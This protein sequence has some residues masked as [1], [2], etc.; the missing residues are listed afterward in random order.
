MNFKFTDN[1]IYIVPNSLK[2]KLL[3]IL[4]ND[5]KIY[6]ITFISLEE[7][8]KHYFFDIK[9]DSLLYLLDKT[10]EN[11]D[12]L[13]LMLKNLYKIDITK[14]YKESKLN[15]LKRLYYD[16]KDNNYLVFDNGYKEYLLTKNI[17]ILGYSMLEPYEKEML[18]SI[19]TNYLDISGN[20]SIDTVYTYHS[21]KDE[22]ISTALKIRELN[23]KCVSYN[24]IFLAGID[25]S[26]NYL[27]KTFFSMFD[28]PLYLKSTNKL[29]SLISVKEYLKDKDI[30][31]IKDINLKS[32][33]IKIES[34]LSYAKNS[35]YYD[36]LLKD[37]LDNTTIDSIELVE[38]VK[39]LNEALD[40]PYLVSDDEYLFVLGFNQNYLPKIYKDEE[41]LS[42]NLKNK[43][44]LNTSFIKN[45]LSK[46]NLVKVLGTIK[47]LTISYKLT[48]LTGEYAKSSLLNELNLKEVDSFNY[49]YNYSRDFNSYRVSSVLDNYY[50]YHEKDNDFDFL[51]TNIDTSKYTSFD[52]K[53]KGINRE[54]TPY[55]LSYSSID[56]LAKC[57]FK[58]YLKYILKLDSFDE[59]F[60]TKIGN[61]FHSILKDSYSNNFSFEESLNKAL[62]DNPLDKRES[63]LFKRLE[64]ELQEI[65]NYNKQVEKRSF[66]TEFYGEKR[67]EIP[68][69]EHA[70]LKG[71]IDKILFKTFHDKTYYAVFDYKTGNATL[72]LDY[73]EDGLYLQLPLYI[74][75]INKSNLFDNPSFVGFF[76]QYLLQNYKDSEE[77]IKNLKLVGYTTD[78]KVILSYLDEDYENNSFVK[79]LSVKKDGE[80]SSRSKVLSDS[81][82]EDIMNSINK[83]LE[84]SLKI[85]DNNAFDIAPKIINNKN[86]SCEFC[87]FKEVCFVSAS[88]YIYLTKKEGDDNA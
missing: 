34:D 57:P 66:L 4:S 65:V 28:I 12:V 17:Y 58:Y 5:S 1:S 44:N 37:K 47:N 53:F 39:V 16:L 38:S 6:N 55:S 22:I 85:I 88:D 68:L 69:S 48:S 26:Y 86:I 27:L 23:S 67:L 45:K 73:L 49:N 43:C 13:R 84:K 21:M 41:Y 2:L 18:D 20:L 24:K 40:V 30:S 46:E 19:N 35:K 31:H 83:A 64:T 82:L 87:P 36:I 10:N 60:N 25:N 32:K 76:Y 8:E 3:D 71:F 9:E 15:N 79:G 81:E 11:I 50:K 29:T 77:Q 72:N 56:D 33:I 52:H 78:D 74:Y 62:K 42:D 14:E 70:T 63:I 61:I 51:T 59:N 54:V 80:L 75:L 7:L